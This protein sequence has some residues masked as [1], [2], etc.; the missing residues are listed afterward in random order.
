VSFP[1]SFQDCALHRYPIV[2]EEVVLSVLKKWFM[3]TKDSL[4]KKMKREGRLEEFDTIAESVANHEDTTHELH[5]VIV[6]G[7]ADNDE[8]GNDVEDQKDF[9]DHII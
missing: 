6:E 5:Q 9:F 4:R 8:D 7:S 2:A 3:R 1:I